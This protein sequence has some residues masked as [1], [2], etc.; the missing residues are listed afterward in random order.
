MRKFLQ[1][2]AVIGGGVIAAALFA[3]PA[4]AGS[5]DAPSGNP[6]VWP[7]DAAGT[8][9]YQDVTVSGYP[10]GVNVY[11]EVCDGT[12]PA[13]TPGWDP[14]EHC[15]SASSPSPIPGPQ[16]DVPRDRLQPPVP[17]VQG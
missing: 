8:P 5:I 9:T 6:T 16:R 7:G 17:A 10:A 1:L 12:D 15:D 13:T 4:F 14:T 2:L 3:A 11:V